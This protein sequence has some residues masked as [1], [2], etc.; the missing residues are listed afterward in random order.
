MAMM[1]EGGYHDDGDYY[2]NLYRREKKRNKEL[3]EKN[4]I[5]QKELKE[6]KN[7][8]IKRS[9]EAIF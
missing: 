1:W 9:K 8:T 5:I 4:K 2:E 7:G 3:E 6:I